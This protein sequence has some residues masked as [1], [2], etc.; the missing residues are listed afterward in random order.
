M[1]YGGLGV[2]L[3]DPLTSLWN[4]FVNILPGLV[5]AIIILIVG[6][7]VA[8]VIGHAVKVILERIGLDAKVRKA[9]LIKQQGHMHFPGIFGEIVK[10]FIFLIFLQQAVAFLHFGILQSLLDQFVTWLP[11]VIAAALIILFGIGLAHFVEHKMLEH[12]SMAGIRQSAKAIKALI[13]I[14]LFIV[15]LKQI[16]IQTSLLENIIIILVAG[17]ALGVA[18]AMG[19]GTGLGKNSIIMD[20]LTG[21]KTVGKKK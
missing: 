16:G 11:H 3:L 19:I 17:F 8:L 14:V 20:Y 15:A 18:L 7:L 13:M 2:P 5:L 10:W 9:N 12:S 21:K 6:Y 4:S 1:E